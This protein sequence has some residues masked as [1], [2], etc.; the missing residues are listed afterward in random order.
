MLTPRIRILDLSTLFG[1]GETKSL[2]AGADE[3]GFTFI[4]NLDQRTVSTTSAASTSKADRSGVI[5]G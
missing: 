4:Y 5:F 3:N 1:R 2:I